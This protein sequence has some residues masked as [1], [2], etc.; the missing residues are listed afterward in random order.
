MPT[1]QMCFEDMLQLGMKHPQFAEARSVIA[2]DVPRT[3]LSSDAPQS[4]W[5][6]EAVDPLPLAERAETLSRILTALAA[7]CPS[8]GYCQGLDMV[9][10]FALSVAEE[11]GT[12]AD[13]VELESAV[14]AF[15]RTLL[16]LGVQDWFEPPLLGL[17]AATF[18]FWKLL[19]SDLPLLAKHLATECVGCE[20]LVL[21]WLQTLFCGVRWM[22]RAVLSRIWEAWLLDGTPKALFRTALML[23]QQSADSLSHSSLED[24]S[25][26]LKQCPP[27]LS[28]LSR[29]PSCFMELA[30]HTKVTSRVLRSLMAEG[31]VACENS[32]L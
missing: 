15:L 1:E 3:L 9:C 17:R 13:C 22:P 24:I 30:W 19:E 7:A 27:H 5:P 28:S 29:K 25:F 31:K 16:E 8:I 4:L 20:L 26:Q 23:F 12:W 21:P 11:A 18:A 32:C 2:A 6:E 14:F 10:A